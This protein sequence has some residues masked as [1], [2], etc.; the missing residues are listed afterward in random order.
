MLYG[1]SIVYCMDCI[2][3]YFK[4]KNHLFQNGIEV[5]QSYAY[6]IRKVYLNNPVQ[7]VD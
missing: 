3:M 1:V 7:N 5:E 2:L 4:V 6:M